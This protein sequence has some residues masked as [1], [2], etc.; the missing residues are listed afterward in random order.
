[1]DETKLLVILRELDDPGRLERP[2]H[3]DRAATGLAFGGLVR[4]LEA[5]FGAPCESERD[6]QDSSGYGRVWVPADATIRG[7]RIVI[8]VSKFGSLAEV[9]AD[10]PGAFLGTD[11]ACEEGALDPADLATVE[12]AL[13][14]LGYVDV[15]EE[16]LESDYLGPS[17]LKPFAARPTWWTRFF[18]TVW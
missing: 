8:C 3:Y 11:E 17:A 14:E 4:R 7:T 10:N 5:D 2:L 12:Q 15:P 9:C 13:A 18:G 1:M 16:L 6:T